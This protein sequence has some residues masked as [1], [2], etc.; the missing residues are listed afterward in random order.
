MML[1][2]I[3]TISKITVTSVNFHPFCIYVT[4]YSNKVPKVNLYFRPIHKHHQ[5]KAPKKRYKLC[6]QLPERI[7]FWLPNLQV[8]F[9][10]FFKT[11]ITTKLKYK[12]I[13][14]PDL[15]KNNSLVN[16]LKQIFSE[17]NVVSYMQM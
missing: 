4:R 12:M 15:A 7:A 1:K 14:Y 5:K 10:F 17:I 16:V 9:F 3:C 6:F 13:F 2:K 11:Q 8:G